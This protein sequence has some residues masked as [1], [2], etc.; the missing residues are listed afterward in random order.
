M[1]RFQ[2]RSH[3]IDGI[4]QGGLKR[5]LSSFARDPDHQLQLEKS[6]RM[7]D[8]ILVYFV[9]KRFFFLRLIQLNSMAYV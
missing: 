3:C 7:W 9:S 1:L 5:S 8:L 4:E 6:M 2:V